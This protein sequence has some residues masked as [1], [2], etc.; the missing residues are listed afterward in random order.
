MKNIPKIQLVLSNLAVLLQSG[1]ENNWAHLLNQLNHEIENEPNAAFSKLFS[2]FGGMG[3][4]GDIVLYRDGQPLIA[5]NNEL[6]ELRS[7]LYELCH[8]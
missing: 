1:G 6:S 5:E 8:E 2:L 4:F 3:S 7:T